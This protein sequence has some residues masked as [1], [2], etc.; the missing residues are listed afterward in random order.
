MSVIRVRIGHANQRFEERSLSPGRYLLGRESCDI[1]LADE[2]VSARHA[3][4]HV[5]APGG[6]SS[7]LQITD[8]GSRNG[9]YDPRGQRLAAPYLLVP[10]QPI[11][12]G[13]SSL[14][15]L[16]PQPTAA[17]S[18]ASGLAQAE[19]RR[20]AFGLWLFWAGTL[21]GAL[22]AYVLFIQPL[23]DAGDSEELGAMFTGALLAIPAGLVYLTVP[24]LLDR[25][26]PEP[27]YALCGCLLW[28][29]LAAVGFSAAINTAV[30]SFATLLGGAKLATFAGAVVSAPLVEEFWKGLGVLGV[31]LFLRREFD[32]VID[33]IMYATFT[34]IGFATIENVTYYA[35]AAAGGDGMLQATFVMRGILSPW[36]HPVFTSM[37]G[38]GLG[39]ARETT[40]P[41]LRWLAPLGG[42]LAAVSLHGFWNGVAT[43]QGF[44]G[45]PLLAL[46][47]PL[48]A[49]FVLSFFGF[50]VVLVVRRS[51]IIRHFLED[52]IHMGNLSRADVRR[53]CQ[54]FGLF[55]AR[56]EQ[57]PAGVEFLRAAARLA[58]SK[59]H[60]AR[61][62]KAKKLTLSADFI[63]PLRQQLAAYR[64]QV[65]RATGSTAR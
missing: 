60:F 32:G 7:A 4:L 11:R 57:G 21:F 42:Y 52:E 28:G 54:P 25:F 19:Q 30:A 45:S 59:W 61:A 33:G 34:A 10:N 18:T 47:L 2:N 3:E 53:V 39:L 29:A 23:I 38:I 64:K 31:F 65:G 9:T 63:A 58:L 36:C 35:T 13:A 51:R 26:D 44:V 27:W 1:V 48:W 22:L 16:E 56:L 6:V 46:T 40:D 8:L 15:W 12:L 37:T 41:R 50:M 55:Q 43:L 24:R 62:A 5:Q 20:R 49:L 14:T 17:P